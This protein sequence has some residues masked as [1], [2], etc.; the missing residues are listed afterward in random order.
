MLRIIIGDATFEVDFPT[1]AGYSYRESEEHCGCAFCRNF[2][3]ALDENYPKIRDFL[4][5]FGIDAEAP[6]HMIPK[7]LQDGKIAYSPEYKVFGTMNHSICLELALDNALVT[8]APAGEDT[9]DITVKN[10]VLPWVL[11]EP[12]PSANAI[13]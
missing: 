4:A 13:P 6:D 9:F 1:T 3:Q 7:L 8:F 2:Y 5:N 11:T 10:L 12:M